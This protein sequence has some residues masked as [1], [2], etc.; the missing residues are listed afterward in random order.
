MPVVQYEKDELAYRLVLVCH[1]ARRRRL[2]HGKRGVVGD[3][4]R[5]LVETRQNWRLQRYL[6]KDETELKLNYLRGLHTLNVVR[7][8]RLLFLRLRNTYNNCR[9]KTV[10]SSLF[11]GTPN[12][13]ITVKY[14]TV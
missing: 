12:F 4:D 7:E 5:Q 11:L 8:S 13:S 1:V 3:R 9:R 2:C 14:N 10:D 6:Q